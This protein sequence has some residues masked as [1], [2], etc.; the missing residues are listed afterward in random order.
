MFVEGT[1]EVTFEKFVVIDRLGNDTTHKLHKK[2][3]EPQTNGPGTTN[4]EIGQV[5]GI[6][7][8]KRVDGIG[9]MVT[10]RGL[11]EGVIGVEDFARNDQIPLPKNPTSVL[12]IFAIKY[13]VETRS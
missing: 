3:N 12:T 6:D 10:R 4:L 11:E 2:Q 5:V 9:A 7:I 1:R 8:R 13:D